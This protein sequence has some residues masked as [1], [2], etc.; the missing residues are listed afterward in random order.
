MATPIPLIA[1]VNDFS[2]A[3]ILISLIQF[4]ISFIIRTLKEE[5][6]NTKL[7]HFHVGQT[8]GQNTLCGILAVAPENFVCIRYN[9]L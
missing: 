1:L 2:Q 5:Y 8:W 3:Y 9:S 7:N 6:I 4:N